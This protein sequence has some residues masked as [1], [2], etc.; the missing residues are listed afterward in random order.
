METYSD[1]CSHLTPAC[2]LTSF[3]HPWI[4]TFTTPPPHFPAFCLEM[5]LGFLALVFPSVYS[6]NLSNK[7]SCRGVQRKIPCH[8]FCLN[9]S[10]QDEGWPEL[11]RSASNC[12]YRSLSFLVPEHSPWCHKKSLLSRHDE[13][14]QPCLQLLPWRPPDTASMWDNAVMTPVPCA[15][16]Y[17]TS[18]RW[19]MWSS[20]VNHPWR[21]SRW[22]VA[23][24]KS[25]QI[26]SPP[27]GKRISTT[28]KQITD[29]GIPATLNLAWAVRSYFGWLRVTQ[30]SGQI[31]KST[32]SL[33]HQ[34]I[35]TFVTLLPVHLLAK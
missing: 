4:L 16:P 1:P 23:W 17:R 33:W 24:G 5:V 9:S 31:I 2:P 28:T 34:E 7:N 10:V 13:E 3:A 19:Q 12:I 6:L 8:L 35:M 15:N 11:F 26:A 20:C 32:L 22:I 25:W 29:W 30:L 21:N 18:G 27:K 14:Q